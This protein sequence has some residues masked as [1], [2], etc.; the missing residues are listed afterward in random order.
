MIEHGIE[1]KRATLR[2]LLDSAASLEH[3]I[4]NDHIDHSDELLVVLDRIR[5]LHTEVRHHNLTLEALE[6]RH[7]IV[8]AT[9]NN[10]KSRLPLWKGQYSAASP[11]QILSVENFIKKLQEDAASLREVYDAKKALLAES[12]DNYFTKQKVLLTELHINVKECAHFN[13][14]KITLQAKLSK[15]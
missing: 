1:E 2:S 10:F 12:R 4:S 5:T 8:Q 9:V 14:Q 7:A 6:L 11:N 3:G 15:L 13:T